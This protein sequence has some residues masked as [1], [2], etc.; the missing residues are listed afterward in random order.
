MPYS[1]DATELQEAAGFCRFR[2]HSPVPT[3]CPSAS[4]HLYKI[5]TNLLCLSYA[6]ECS[7]PL[8]DNSSAEVAPSTAVRRATRGNQRQ[9]SL[10]GGHGANRERPEASRAKDT[11]SVRDRLLT[12][13]ARRGRATPRPGSDKGTEGLRASVPFSLAASE[14]GSPSAKDLTRR[15]AKFARV[16]CGG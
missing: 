9:P 11:S 13:Q 8:V 10:S 2:I 3:N 7:I 1:F 12:S 14:S 4:R 5:L 16:C 15:I 6:W